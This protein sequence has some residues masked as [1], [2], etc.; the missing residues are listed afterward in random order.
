[1]E[2]KLA[3]G[4]SVMQKAAVVYSSGTNSRIARKF[5]EPSSLSSPRSFPRSFS[6][7]ADDLQMLSDS[8]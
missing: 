7:A 6:G 5:R 1:M 8:R 2:T 4:G 3:R